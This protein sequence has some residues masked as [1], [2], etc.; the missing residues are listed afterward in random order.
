MGKQLE[1][2][3]TV[4]DYNLQ[5]NIMITVFYRLL[6]GHRGKKDNNAPT[7]PKTVPFSTRILNLKAFLKT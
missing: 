4:L 2:K 6:G 3:R 5:N 7:K 1:D